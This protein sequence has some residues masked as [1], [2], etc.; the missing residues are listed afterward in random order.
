[1]SLN[2]IGI[3]GLSKSYL[4]PPSILL[5]NDNLHH[6]D[7]LD[8]IDTRTI[9]M[10]TF[11]LQPPDNH[12]PDYKVWRK[13]CGEIERAESDQQ[14]GNVSRHIRTFLSWKDSDPG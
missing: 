14:D 3:I 6:S 8:R 4:P 11:S 10:T 13:R 12:T 5:E 2:F 9:V 1:M 7:M